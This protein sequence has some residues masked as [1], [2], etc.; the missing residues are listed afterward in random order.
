MQKAR[1][2][3]T[4]DMSEFEFKEPEISYEKQLTYTV[5]F[6]LVFI[7]SLIGYCL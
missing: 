1:L 6:M 7:G 4:T 3:K 2:N 5:I